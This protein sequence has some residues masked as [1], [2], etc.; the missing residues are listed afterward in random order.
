M[1]VAM[2]VVGMMWMQEEDGNEID[3]QS[4][5]ISTSHF[6]IQMQKWHL[7][8]VLVAQLS[9]KLEGAVVFQTRGFYLTLFPSVHNMF[10][11]KLQVS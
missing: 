9:M 6:R 5:Y 8:C 1:L 11:G 10:Q 3:E 4:M 7:F 2:V